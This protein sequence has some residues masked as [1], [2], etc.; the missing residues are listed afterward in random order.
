[1]EAYRI[2]DSVGNDWGRS[3][4]LFTPTWVRTERGDWGAAVEGAESAIAFA[5]KGGFLPGQVAVGADLGFLYTTIGAEE[6]GRERFEAA[7]ALAREQFTDW[8]AWPVAEAARAAVLRGDLDQAERYLDQLKGYSRVRGDLYMSIHIALATGELALGRGD[9]AAAVNVARTRRHIAADRGIVPFEKDFDLLE[10]DGARRS[11]DLA[12]ARAAYERGIARS[13]EQ[14]SRRLLWR[15]LGGLAAIHQAEGRTEEARRA[16]D[17]AATVIDH[18]AAS[19]KP[20]GL[21]EL[22]R[23]RPAVREAL[24]KVSV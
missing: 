18:I 6:R 11:A 10:A 20:R 17:E 21:D 5:R 3:Y 7:I 12:A 19:L 9:G 2:A 16:R 1:M 23:S 15:L 14:G 24:G 4:A 8:Q 22:F 13:R